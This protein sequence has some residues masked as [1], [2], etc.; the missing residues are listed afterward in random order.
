MGVILS[1]LLKINALKCHKR[2]DRN[3]IAAL[4][5]AL[6]F[7]SYL[8][9]IGQFFLNWQNSVRSTSIVVRSQSKQSPF[10]WQKNG[11]ELNS[12]QYHP[13][14]IISK[15]RKSVL[16]T[17]RLLESLNPH[18]GVGNQGRRSWVRRIHICAP[19]TVRWEYFKWSCKTF[20]QD[21][22]RLK[23]HDLEVPYIFSTWHRIHQLG[24]L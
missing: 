16:C 6:K 8:L 22:Y 11:P 10:K 3:S 14:S 23:K 17:I 20:Q 19:N 21:Q 4:W 2:M 13:S 5:S 9:E 15:R 24:S 18:S 7:N 12:L 1:G